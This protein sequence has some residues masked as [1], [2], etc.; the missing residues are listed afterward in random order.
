MAWL[1][2]GKTKIFACFAWLVAGD[3]AG[4]GA[5][6]MCCDL[7]WHPACD[8]LPFFL[9][10]YQVL[11]PCICILVGLVCLKEEDLSSL[12]SLPPYLSW[13]TDPCV[14]ISQDMATHDR[15]TCDQTVRKMWWCRG[16]KRT[17]LPVTFSQW[18]R[19]WRGVT[20]MVGLWDMHGMVV[21]FSSP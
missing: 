20:F 17:T 4:W 1:A 11:L 10:L 13:R 21:P 6:N 5:D 3:M 18:W 16:K 15:K 14:D 19:W 2:G 9:S 7:H 12:L 8:M